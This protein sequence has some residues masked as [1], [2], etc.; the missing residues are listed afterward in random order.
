[1]LSKVSV[2]TCEAGDWTGL[3]LDGKLFSQGHSIPHFEW[4]QLLRKLGVETYEF[5]ESDG[6]F[7]ENLG[8]FGGRFPQDIAEVEKYID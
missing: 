4:L 7:G 8:V 3:Y 2:I 5:Y 6:Q 1:M